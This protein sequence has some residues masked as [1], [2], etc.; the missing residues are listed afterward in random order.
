[1][2]LKAGGV[3][4]DSAVFPSPSRKVSVPILIEGLRKGHQRHHPPSLG[5][6]YPDPTGQSSWSRPSAGL[7]PEPGCLGVIT[8]KRRGA[9]ATKEGTRK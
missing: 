9:L 7:P 8:D 1:M 4:G 2:S 3:G 5:R 6:R